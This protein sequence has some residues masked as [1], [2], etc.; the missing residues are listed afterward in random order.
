[1]NERIRQ[2]EGQNMHNGKDSCS[3]KLQLA[4]ATGASLQPA[5]ENKKNIMTLK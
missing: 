2:K 5:S 4:G 1:M 3:N